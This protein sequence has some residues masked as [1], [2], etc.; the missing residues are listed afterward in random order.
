MARPR[1]PRKLLAIHQAA[2]QLLVKTGF[3]GLKMA[4][5]AAEAQLATGTL[6]IYYKNKEALIN[7]VF[8]ATQEEIRACLEEPTLE[9]ETF[10]ETFEARWKAYFQFCFAQPDKMLFV[11]QFQYSGLVS[12]KTISKAESLFTG[13]DEFLIKGQ[14][15]GFLR[16]M[17]LGIIKAQLRGATHEIVKKMQQTVT[18]CSEDALDLCFDLAW[19]SVRK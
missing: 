19:N 3:T 11:E 1:D 2:T 4:Q 18:E 14:K 7:G 9:Q 10:Y 5:V 6:Y 15:Q 17:D 12:E 16:R 8:L 13:Y